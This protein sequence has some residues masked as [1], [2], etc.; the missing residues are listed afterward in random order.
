MIKLKDE[1][2]GG[3]DIRGRISKGLTTQDRQRLARAEGVAGR[4]LRCA[5]CDPDTIFTTPL[6]GTHPS[7]TVRI[8]EMVTGDL[9]TEVENLY[10]CDASVFPEALARPTVLTIISLARRLA[11]HL[12]A[13]A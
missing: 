5:G 12:T 4:I 8:G 9:Q 3:V 10:V 13:S 7:G 6:R 2:S 11:R 1:V